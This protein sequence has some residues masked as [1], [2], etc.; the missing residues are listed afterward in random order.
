MFNLT[1]LKWHSLNLQLFV[2]RNSNFRNF[3]YISIF[4]TGVAR[5]GIILASVAA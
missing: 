4:W 5:G 3:S 2:R 1:T